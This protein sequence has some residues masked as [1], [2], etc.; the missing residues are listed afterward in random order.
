MMFF[1]GNNPD[2]IAFNS[3]TTLNVAKEVVDKHFAVVGVL[4]HLVQDLSLVGE[5]QA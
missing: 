4:E 3:A 1:C 5:E 2:C